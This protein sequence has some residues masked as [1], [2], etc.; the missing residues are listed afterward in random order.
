MTRYC[1]SMESSLLGR[2]ERA[3]GSTNDLVRDAQRSLRVRPCPRVA[4]DGC[5]SIWG[6]RF[7]WFRKELCS[8]T[9]KVSELIA[10]LKH[11]M[12]AS[13]EDAS[14]IVEALAEMG[15]IKV[16][17]C[18]HNDSYRTE[19]GAAIVLFPKG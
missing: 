10:Y 18:Q 19:D 1:D 12:D 3:F 11:K 13:V 16:W 9:V 4:Q 6:K 15:L 5:Y 8:R 7:K 2:I 14:G 17:H